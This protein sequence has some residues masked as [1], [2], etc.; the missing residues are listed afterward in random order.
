MSYT[1]LYY[2][3][4]KKRVVG[5]AEFHNSHLGAM[6]VWVNLY[7]KHFED[8]IAESTKLYGWK[9]TAPVSED[10]YSA[11]WGLFKKPDIPVYERAVLGSTFDRVILE[12][13]HFDRFY[14][15][16]MKYAVCY[17]AGTLL[18]QATTIQKLSKRNVI[19]VCWNHTSV[20]G[21]M[22]DE[23]KEWAKNDELWS[24]YKDI[25]K[26]QDGDK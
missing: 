12:K 7:G 1:E 26:K 25:D 19:G 15:D 10:D 13:E 20:N 2:V 6:R 23:L 21:D 24:L 8:R 17:A 18:Y 16:C 3:T 9:P 22:Y 4:P 14:E 11:L 5:H